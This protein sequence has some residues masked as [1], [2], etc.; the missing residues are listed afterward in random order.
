MTNYYESINSTYTYKT[1]NQQIETKKQINHFF[2]QC[3]TYFKGH[4]RR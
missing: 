2:D 4:T 1:I 3:Q